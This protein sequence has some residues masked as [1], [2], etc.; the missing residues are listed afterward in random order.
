MP[1]LS[2]YGETVRV[3][4]TADEEAECYRPETN[5][6]RQKSPVAI[7][8]THNSQRIVAQRGTFTVWG[9]DTRSME[10]YTEDLQEP[11]LWQIA[12]DAPRADLFASLQRLGFSETM[13]FPEL[14]YLAE[15]LK[16]L[17]GWR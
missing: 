7:F 16:R 10:R 4:T 14:S 15:E 1:A 5:R 17:E 11:V 8:G 13:V 9:S 3:L 6:K 12:L 2:E